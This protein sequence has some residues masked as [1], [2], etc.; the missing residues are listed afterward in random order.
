MNNTATN[1]SSVVSGGTNNV[2]GGYAAA[3]PGGDGNLALGDYAFAAGHKAQA[4]NNNSF[5]WSD[6]STNTVST[7]NNQFV[8]R[9]RNGFVFLT[10]TNAI[11]G[12]S[13]TPGATSWAT[14]SDRNAKKDFAPVDTGAVLDKLA[15]VPVEQWHYKWEAAGSTPNLGPMAQDFIH[16]FYPGRDDKSITTLEFEGWNWRRSRD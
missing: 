10:S 11:T 12:G 6:G 1:M 9:A 16:A 15:A 7:T 4:T 2:S 14:I 8:A 13:L 5:V 3:V